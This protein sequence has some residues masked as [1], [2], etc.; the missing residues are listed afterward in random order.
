[1]IDHDLSHQLHSLAATV[2]EPFDLA[3]LHRR[4]SVH[5][6]RRAAV[7]VGFA[8][9]GVAVVVGGLFVVREERPG[10]VDIELPATSP[11]ATSTS[12]VEPTTLPDCA[13]VLA[14]LQA[15]KTTPDTV[16]VNDI[17]TDTSASAGDEPGSGFKG[18]V[19]ILA[20]DGPRLTFRSDEPNTPTS[21]TGT[22]DAATVWF[23]GSTQLD[24]PP[25]LQVG[26]HVGLGKRLASDGLD[27][28]VFVD[29][30]ESAGVD[31]MPAPDKRLSTT[32]GS[33]TAVSDPP[34]TPD[35]KIV[36]PGPTLPPGPTEKSVGTITGTDATSINVT[37]DDRS[38]QATTF[39]IDLASTPFYAGDTRCVPGSLTVGTTLGVAYHFDDAGSVISDDVMLMP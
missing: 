19:T 25:T 26:E 36:V 18:T 12:Q 11:L 22:L 14:G 7:K 28:V 29:V 17:P 16:V 9:A 37:L 33:S 10:P 39:A 34:A 31:G 1:M 21:G 2:D 6:R 13:V 27:H 38:G 4:I 35:T 3:A 20:I 30:S 32:A 15:A 8:G 23:D 24:S 5:S